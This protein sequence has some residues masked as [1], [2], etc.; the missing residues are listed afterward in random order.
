MQTNTIKLLASLIAFSC[1]TTDAAKGDVNSFNDAV[2]AA[3]A[4]QADADSVKA[5][6]N[7]IARTAAQLRAIAYDAKVR[8]SKPNASQKADA[9]FND[10]Y[11]NARAAA[12]A[13]A[14]TNHSALKAQAYADGLQNKV[15]GVSMRDQIAAQ[16]A[17]AIA[18]DVANSQAQAQ[19]L[20]AHTQRYKD[21]IN[22][23]VKDLD[24]DTKID[25]NINGKHLTTTAGALAKIAPQLQIAT[26][27]NSAFSG[28]SHRG[29]NSPSKNGN[30]RGT[31]NG[32]NNAQNSRS[33]GALADSHVG[34][35]RSGGGF[36][37]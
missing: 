29:N 9:A 36:H 25:A 13:L 14:Y 4:A 10:A 20:Y 26:A 16:Q 22:V 12:D 27:F 11:A 32:A 33:A 7:Q 5:G 3:S 18:A 17:A 15:N 35:G 1:G 8:A 6:A 37:Y 21:R 24:P 23:P 31:G 34:G 28:P 2:A 19:Q 30:M